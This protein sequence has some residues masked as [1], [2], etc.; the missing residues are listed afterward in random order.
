V[1]DFVGEVVVAVCVRW[2][3]VGGMECV[4]VWGGGACVLT[5]RHIDKQR[6]KSWDNS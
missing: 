2:C 4:C 5:V 1:V 6:S 3:G